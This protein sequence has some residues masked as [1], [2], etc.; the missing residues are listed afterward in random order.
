[1]V[2]DYFKK[3]SSIPRGS[4]NNTRISNYLVDFARENNLKYYQDE[5]ENV[6]IY[7]DATPG[8]ETCPP[9]ILQGHMDMVC[10]KTGDSDHD[11]ENEGLV[12]VENDGFLM[13]KD[14]T[15][16]ADDGIAIA[17]MLDI[18]TN[19]KLIH[20]PLEMLITTDEEIGMEG[21]K[22]FD[23]G[24]LKGRHMINLDSEEEGSFVCA[25]AGGGTAA[26]TCP[27]KRESFGG[28]LITIEV[29]GLKGGHSGTEIDKNRTNACKLL[30]RILSYLPVDSY[31][32]LDIYGG[33]KDNV[34][35]NEAVA[36]LV[37]S[38]QNVD[39]IDELISE[40]AVIVTDEL[41]VSE[42]DLSVSIS[43]DDPENE[44]ESYEV[45]DVDACVRLLHALMYIPNGVQVMSAA[46]PG[47]VES[48]ENIGILGCGEDNI[49]IVVSMRSQKKT[50]MDYMT[51]ILK[52]IADTIGADF[53]V[54]GEYPGYDMSEESDFRN[55][56]SGVYEN[57]YGKKPEI[58]AIHAG[59][60]I[61]VLADKL[62]GLDIISIGP[63]TYDIHTVNERLD[64]A[65][66]DRIKSFL[67]EAL[68]KFA[69]KYDKDTDI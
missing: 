37:V 12:L 24:V 35:P 25:C 46:I 32:I 30:G 48:S 40:A 6:V 65:S 21:A 10:E 13:A 26:I 14:T 9:L 16:G 58:C 45:I 18:L 60:E 2:I 29:N 31:R 68:D 5:Y 23:A 27:V 44:D 11:F 41:L 47:M 15:L 3:I 66:V 19:D 43:Y 52:N 54:S 63:E 61:G 38:G 17:Y 22:H 28:E 57:I 42:P 49:K 33:R 7:K 55:L 34:I 56:M 8:Y 64:L 20:P 69:K 53:V 62:P 67:L 59:L 4:G 51:G 50:Y 1:M 36:K 39:Y